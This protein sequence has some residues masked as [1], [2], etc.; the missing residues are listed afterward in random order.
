MKKI[1]AITAKEL[2]LLVRDRAGLLVLFV[3]PAILVIVITLVQENI[4]E[5]TGQQTTEI[6]FVNRDHGA[7]AASLRKFLQTERLQIKTFQG[8]DQQLKSLL[9]D[10]TFQAGVIVPS[11]TTTQLGR[12]ISRHL[13]G[14]GT[15][16][17]LAPAGK[18]PLSVFFDPAAMA[19][20]KIGILSRVR[21][22]SRAAEMEMTAAQLGKSIAE[23]IGRLPPGLQPAVI[24]KNAIKQAFGR[25]FVRVAGQSAVSQ[26][27][28]LSEVENPVNR[29]VAAWALFG[30]FFTAIPIAGTLLAERRSGI[31][32]RL[33]G[34]PVSPLALFTGKVIAYLG[35]CLCQFL[36]IGIIGIALFPHLGLPAFTLPGSPAT[37]LPVILAAGLAACGFGV[38]LGSFCRSYEQASTLGSTLVV[39]A[40]A[41]G[42]VMVP[43][44]AMPQVMQKIS[45]LSPL[46]WGVNAFLDL[47]IRGKGL[48]A[49]TGDLALLLGFAMVAVLLSWRRSS[50]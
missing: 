40:A 1:F 2:R 13:A 50:W 6:L 35:I 44:Y 10:G 7:F 4:L 18:V 42:G 9:A 26:K 29:N 49:T 39:I 30:M 19:G 27:I 5:L 33:A 37:L 16:P 32:T 31:A 48:G 11:G 46:N 23:M 41:M 14:K 36:L 43:V 15:P 12:E 25:S 3:M 17:A 22:A 28:V 45:I 34:M 38:F 21:M 24:S 20:F 47:L 8:R